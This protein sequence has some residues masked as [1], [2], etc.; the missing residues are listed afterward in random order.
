MC[1][2]LCLVLTILLQEW[3]GTIRGVQ[4]S[5]VACLANTKGEEIIYIPNE[6]IPSK[7]QQMVRL[8]IRVSFEPKDL[9]VIL[10]L[11]SSMGGFESQTR[12]REIWGEAE[13]PCWIPAH[14]S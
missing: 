13:V 7:R 12:S 4:T 11:E 2:V 6:I 14:R 9:I 5:Q 3:N 8:G 1:S 10:V